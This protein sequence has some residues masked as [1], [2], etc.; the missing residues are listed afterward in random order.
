MECVQI[1]LIVID[2]DKNIYC[3]CKY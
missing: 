2:Q 3:R 1:A